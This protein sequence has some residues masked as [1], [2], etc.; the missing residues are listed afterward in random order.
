MPILTKLKQGEK[1]NDEDILLILQKREDLLKEVEENKTRY[2]EEIKHLDTVISELEK[3]RLQTNDATPI[4][5]KEEELRNEY[6]RILALV[7]EKESIINH[8]W[9][10]YHQLPYDVKKTLEILYV[11]SKGWKCVCDELHIG[12][13]KAI[14]LKNRGITEIISKI[15]E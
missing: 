9:F 15:D 14:D 7:C 1:L 10:H 6:K 13:G 3:I 8:V 5:K 11:S 12:K 4:K 2:I